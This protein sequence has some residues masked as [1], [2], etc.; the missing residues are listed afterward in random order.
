MRRFAEI[1]QGRVWAPAAAAV[2]LGTAWASGPFMRELAV[3]AATAW[4]VVA[5]RLRSRGRTLVGPAAAWLAIILIV[6][7]LAQSR[8]CSDLL[9]APDLPIRGRTAPL[10]MIRVTSAPLPI[11][12]GLAFEGDWLSTCSLPIRDGGSCQRRNG[13]VRVHM[14]G[15]RAPPAIGDVLRAPGFVTPAPGYGNPGAD[16]LRRTWARRGLV[17][18]LSIQAS[19]V[20]MPPHGVGRPISFAAHIRRAIGRVRTGAALHLAAALPG[21][22]GGVVRALGLGD[23]GGI[24]V[25]L[26]RVLR[27]SGTAHILAVSG[28]HVGLLVLL[29]AGLL[30]MLVAGLWVSLLRRWSFWQLA[31]APCLMAAWS[32]VLL[33]G[34]AASTL[35]AASMATLALLV[36]ATS[37]RFDLAES[38]GL[39]AAILVLASPDAVHDVGLQLSILGVMGVTLGG[40]VANRLAG[41]AERPGR[42]LKMF[43]VST[44]AAATTTLVAVPVFGQLPLMAPLANI[45]VVP[46]IGGVVLPLALLVV[47]LTIIS[48]MLGAILPAP[49]TALF[50]TL[51]EWAV[52]PLS[53]AVEAPEWLFV[54]WPLG[55]L[56][57]TLIAILVPCAMLG[58]LLARCR[59]LWLTI[60]LV[61]ALASGPVVG[62]LQQPSESSFEAWFFDVGHGDAILLRLPGGVNMMVDAGG[63]SGDDGRV[64]ERA[65]LPALRHLGVRS[66]DVMVL[67]HPHPDHENGLLAIARALPV[68]EIWW[69]GD[70]A[71]SDEHRQLIEMLRRKGTRWRRWGGPSARPDCARLRLG[72][73]LLSVLWPSGAGTVGVVGGNDRSLVV[74]VATG[75][76]RLLLTG[77]VER[78]AE[79]ALLEQPGLLRS[80][81]VLKVPHHG[82]RTSSTNAFLR[83]LRP[84][85]AVAGARSWGQLPFPHPTVA[86]RYRRHGIALW[87]TEFGAVRLS[88]SAKGWC[89]DQG[90]RSA[91]SPSDLSPLRR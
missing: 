87:P 83:R 67:S 46:W 77:D 31:A 1:L 88:M 25:A 66:I 9:S 45:L 33:T 81:A 71:H 6:G 11:D 90:A 15:R 5:W 19:R 10:Q 52:A 7:V 54:A 65:V 72:G 39:A 24:D 44:G 14:R 85:V 32:Y 22:A 84:V 68:K 12:G 78:A 35:R 56:Q 18:R 75:R 34:A 49:L 20:R 42:L 60:S 29:V 79:R 23:R 61:L 57:A 89:I 70:H 26:R 30:R 37:T 63:E 28:A 76:H 55:G 82:S 41:S 69:T 38:L 91:C 58:L 47:G 2:W 50:G 80:V 13:G 27:D 59:R 4:L 51:T 21:R 17:G 36:R 62:A 64:G 86:R 53:A 74:E 8:R 40:Q 43:A 16:Q 48:Q 73:V 3:L